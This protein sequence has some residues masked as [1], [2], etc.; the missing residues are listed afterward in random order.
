MEFHL[1]VWCKEVV[2]KMMNS[3]KWKFGKEQ[4]K[5]K[6]KCNNIGLFL[7]LLFLTLL[8]FNLLGQACCSGGV[9]LG[10]TLGLGTAEDK[11]LQF[12][13]TYDRNV[14]KD[15]M[16]FRILLDDNSRSRFTTSTLLE[17]NYGISERFAITGVFPYVRQERRIK[18][19]QGKEDITLTE[20]WGDMILLLKYNL[21]DPNK[22]ANSQWIVGIGP[23][24]PTGETNFKNNQGLTL[25]ADMQPGSGSW[26][27]FFWIFFQKSKFIVPSLSL[28]KVITYRKSGKNKNYNGSQVYQFGDEFMF[29]LGLNYNFLIH[30]PTDIFVFG[31]YRS[32]TV[33]LIDENVFP[34]SGGKWGYLI[35]GLNISFH[36][37]IALRASVDLPVYRNLKG[38]QLTTTYKYNISLFYQFSW[39]DAGKNKFKL[40]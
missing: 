31:R 7:L 4:T 29:N 33:D 5:M 22:P 37:N 24:I 6:G 30:W 11:S 35:P 9:P 39:N 26:D 12:L 36:P 3:Q 1:K 16:D 27:T 40:E 18:G 20:G 23:K 28:M 19:F 2:D 8:P 13:L 14:L 17:I 32:Q 21:L 25:V 15:L 10:G 34:G 38:T